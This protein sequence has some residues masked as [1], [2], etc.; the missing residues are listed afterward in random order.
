MRTTFHRS[1]VTHRQMGLIVTSKMAQL[2]LL[3]GG[4][5]RGGALGCRGE[6]EGGAPPEGEAPPLTT[7]VDSRLRQR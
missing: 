5:E 4:M 7:N 6:G 3:R 2:I 1:V